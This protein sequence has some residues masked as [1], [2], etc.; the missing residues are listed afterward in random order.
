MPLDM[1]LLSGMLVRIVQL[2]MTLRRFN[3]SGKQ[4]REI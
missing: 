3:A 2:G 4:S 1:R